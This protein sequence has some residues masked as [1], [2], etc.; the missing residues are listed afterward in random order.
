MYL[1][2]YQVPAYLVDNDN[3]GSF[4]F[5][6]RSTYLLTQLHTYYSTTAETTRRESE[7]KSIFTQMT[8]G[9]QQLTGAS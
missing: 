2:L 7:M 8:R 3:K 4:V 9:P 1:L 6:G 5:V